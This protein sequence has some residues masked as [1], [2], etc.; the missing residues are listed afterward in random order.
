MA[1]LLGLQRFKRYKRFL[2]IKYGMPYKGQ[3]ESVL[4]YIQTH[5]SDS[6]VRLAAENALKLK[7]YKP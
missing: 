4:E 1:L 6:T 3:I 2:G 5:D 7:D